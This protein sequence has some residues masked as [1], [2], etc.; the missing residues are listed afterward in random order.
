MKEPLSTFIIYAREDWE[1][2]EKFKKHLH[3]LVRCKELFVWYDG[4]ILGGMEWDKEIKDKLDS[5]DIVLLIITSSFFNSDYIF[6]VELPRAIERCDDNLCKIIPI[7]FTDCAWELE[8]HISKFQ[9]LPLNGKPIFSDHGF[10]ENRIMKEV[11]MSIQKSA[12]E[13]REL[14]SLQVQPVLEEISGQIEITSEKDIDVKKNTHSDGILKSFRHASIQLQNWKSEFEH[15]PNSHL[16]RL[17][18]YQI[19]NW[20]EAPLPRDEK[21][22]ALLI[23]DAGMGKSVIMRDVLRALEEREIPVLG[24][25]ADQYCVETIELLEKRLHLND[26]IEEMV[27]VL[28]LTNERVVVLI[29]QIDALSQSLSARR[30]YLETFT[31]LVW[32]LSEIPAVRIVISCRTYD[33]Q[34]DHDLSFYR[35][36]KK[37]EIKELSDEHVNTILQRLSLEM[38]KLSPD[39]KKLLKTPLHLDVFCRIYR[40]DLPFERIR[41]LRDLY[42]EFWFQKVDEAR[43]PEGSRVNP[44]KITTLIFELARAMYDRQNLEVSPNLFRAAY[45]SELA[46][47]KSAGIMF[48]S[49]NGVVFF[50]QTFYDFAYARQFVKSGVPIEKYLLDNGQGLHIRSC[51]K[52]MMEFLRET[53]P[54]EYL[55]VLR[56]V[57]TSPDFYFHIKSLL[58]SLLGFVKNPTNTE[59][60]LARDLVFP[61]PSL[62][63]AFVSSAKSREWLLFLFEE[64]QPQRLVE[65]G[66][67][68]SNA[69]LDGVE[70]ERFSNQ[71][72]IL[73]A[74]LLRHL[75]ESRNEIL[76]FLWELPE[77][78]FKS[79]L[80]ERTLK[81]IGTWD[82]AL[83]FKLFDAYAS[84]MPDFV[85][86][87]LLEKAS[88]HNSQWALEHLKTAIEKALEVKSSPFGEVRFEY[89]LS[90][91]IAHFTENYPE[92]T[93]DLLLDF[94]M[95]RL[96]S[97]E[98]SRRSIPPNSI[99]TDFSWI[100]IDID[101]DGH[102]GTGLFSLLIDCVRILAKNKSPRF[103]RFISESLE[104]KSATR[105]LILVEGFRA[106]PS[107]NIDEIY[108]FFQFFLKNGGG[109]ASDTLSWRT[110]QLL[111]EVY[112]QFSDGQ[113][114][115]IVQ[116]ISQVESEDEKVWALKNEKP[117][118]IG[119]VRLRWLMCLPQDD[120]AQ[121][122]AAE[123]SIQELSQRFPDLN[124][125]EPN[126]FKAYWVGPPL[127]HD[128]Y[129]SMSLEEWK[130]SFRKYDDNYK[131]ERFSDRGGMTEH[132]R[133]FQTEVKKRPGFFYPLIEELTA[134]TNFPRTY[135]THGLDGLK[136]AKFPPERLLHLVKK[137]DLSDFESWDIRRLVSLCGYF[138]NEKIEDDFIVHFLVKMA[139]THPEPSDNSLNVKVEND[140]T[141]SIYVSGYNTV[142]GSAVHLLPFLYYFKKHENLVFETLEYVAEHDVLSVRCQMMPRLA[143]LTNL[144]KPRSLQLFLRLI[145]DNEEVIMEHSAWSAQYLAR[146]NFEGMKSYFEKA[147]VHPKLHADAATILS[148]TW[149][150]EGNDAL[151]L[152]NQFIE[153]SDE[154]KAGAIDVA[155]HNIR[156]AEGNP[157][158]RS[159]ELF[160][161]FLEESDE[162]VIRAY[163]AAF[164]HLKPQD[165][166]HLEPVLARFAK[167]VAAR[168]N[169]RPFYEY[170]IACATSHPEACL[171]LVENFADYEKPDI[172]RSGHYDKEP[173]K[174]VINAYNELWGRKIRDH[175]MLRKALLLFDKMLLDD[176][177]RRDAETVLADVER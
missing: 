36:Q 106:K 150:F 125:E 96:L 47:L 158:S 161:R 9:V 107:E 177:F 44:E 127:E 111:K 81:N 52:M 27:K 101:D 31:R 108:H 143:L 90:K 54:K 42:E 105:L 117:E 163:D 68:A 28:A 119:V 104:S 169:P 55:R 164:R 153:M 146:Q 6:E 32:A 131:E 170:M 155:A 65:A 141:R 3:L 97:P 165:F 13:F 64:K 60:Q 134:M 1:A 41:V 94:Q 137:I 10:D 71:V 91:L 48:P 118:W 35:R 20:I 115:H 15:L 114:I 83:A 130:A 162:D 33:L 149:V 151:G 152:L 7:I 172:T 138:T 116:L 126:R 70:R 5:A 53:D 159:I 87:D 139:R 166:P 25:K 88:A 160:S 29:D 144:D 49:R 61:E 167:T 46:Y 34:N 113:R 37:F 142:R 168:K 19:V 98:E 154:A 59:V 176:R 39:L 148:L 171:A 123:K 51:L 84:K 78:E 121:F 89:E 92:M 135:L 140:K 174:V 73:N 80:V 26:G 16:E 72:D 18:T 11:V 132:A 136:E 156:D 103:A 4:E 124:D 40:P 67:K 58:L 86:A 100:A 95:Q 23:G 145:R 38:P 75:P 69:E 8:P 57:L 109:D 21:G 12:S 175:A 24:I 45:S 133:Q 147:L 62:F 122:P 129:E 63:K 128:E 82:N 112:P 99:F 50:H 30:E 43:L 17:E 22:I 77:I 157:V 85:F 14:L 76:T 79:W 2:L 102:D 74:F 66:A 110:R 120:I 56:L 93:F 173:L